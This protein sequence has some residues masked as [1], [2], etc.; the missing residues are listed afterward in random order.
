[1][2]H[3]LFNRAITIFALTTFGI[4]AQLPP[5]DSFSDKATYASAQESTRDVEDEPLVLSA[6][7]DEIEDSQDDEEDVPLPAPIVISDEQIELPPLELETPDGAELTEEQMRALSNQ[8]L[9]R[10]FTDAIGEVAPL[11]EEIDVEELN[12]PGAALLT[13]RR[14]LNLD[15]AVLSPTLDEVS[16]RL[17]EVL[18]IANVDLNATE[19]SAPNRAL[20]QQLDAEIQ[21]LC[22]LWIGAELNRA[23]IGRREYNWK[24]IGAPLFST[25]DETSVEVVGSDWALAPDSPFFFQVTDSLTGEVYYTKAGDF[26]ICDPANLL[27]AALVRD[28]H[29][30]L[31][32]IEEG[33]VAPTGRSER[34]RILKHG[35]IQ[36]VDIANRIVTDVWVGTIPLFIFDNPARLQSDDCVFFT[37]TPASGEPRRVELRP[38]SKVG[39][40]QGKVLTS[41]GKPEEIFARIVV[42]CKSKKRLVEILTQPRLE[43]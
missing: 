24:Q 18:E 36:G 37:P 28:D 10:E 32:S 2:K 12:A 11:P 8:P 35:Q 21:R 41:N 31:L 20:L 1:M 19:I 39:V 9:F 17:D 43:Q 30:Y 42:L 15:G 25:N 7:S 4:A 34:I 29:N 13:P 22:P 27:S 33:K 14:P 40:T 3:N 23:Q 5:D 26:E 6:T 38:G 16:S